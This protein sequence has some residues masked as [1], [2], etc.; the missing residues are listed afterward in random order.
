MKIA[1][2]QERQNE[3][4]R[5]HDA[6]LAFSR[7]EM[8]RLQ[9]DM[10]EQNVRLLR[11]AA[12][13]G[14][15]LALTS[16]AINFPGQLRCM[17]ECASAELVA[18]HQE[19]VIGQLG[20][21]AKEAGMYVVAGLFR[22]GE[23]GNLRNQAVVF[24]RTGKEAHTYTK[25][26]LV[27]D[28]CGYLTAGTGFPIWMSEFGPIGIGVCWD[29]QFPET[30]RAYAKQGANLVLAP[31]WGWEH[32]YARARAYENGVYVAAAMAVPSYKPIE[33]MR[34]PSQ[35]IAP[36]GTVLVEGP[37]DRAGIVV[38]DIDDISDCARYREIRMGCL[39]AWEMR[40]GHDNR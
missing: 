13:E 16:E 6:D 27:G 21:V 14:T 3:L 29:M 19:W 5:F 25:N 40:S 35:V 39:S 37:C 32:A 33:G 17:G 26:F 34:A 31:T 23:D 2:I 11:E 12:K 28:E 18:E 4:Y 22:L 38:A 8:I 36:N 1:L 15:D 9:R 24:D 20:G 30:C 10:V 7:E